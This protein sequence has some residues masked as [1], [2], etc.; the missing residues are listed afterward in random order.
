MPIV[1]LETSHSG[2]SGEGTGKLV[3]VEHSEVSKAHGQVTERPELIVVHETVSRTI[4]G[5]HAV[6]FVSIALE[7]EHAVSIV[8]VVA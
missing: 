8:G 5:F 3:S 7:P 2:E 6:D 1:L 4:H